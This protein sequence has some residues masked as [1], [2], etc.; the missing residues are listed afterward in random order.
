MVYP[1]ELKQ[2]A[3]AEIEKY[4]N[5]DDK[6]MIS[7]FISEGRQRIKALDVLLDMTGSS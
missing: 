1:D 6:Q 5:C 7:F 4:R 2:T 3:R